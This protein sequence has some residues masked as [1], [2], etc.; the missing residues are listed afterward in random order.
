MV[1]EMGIKAPLRKVQSMIK[2]YLQTTGHS[3]GDCELLTE[4]ILYQYAYLEKLI[5]TCKDERD[6]KGP[7]QTLI[8]GK[9]LEYNAEIKEARKMVTNLA[10]MV[11]EAEEKWVKK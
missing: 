3:E 9:D 11:E 6:P 2:E 5:R 10:K 7:S 1:T 4:S 8:R